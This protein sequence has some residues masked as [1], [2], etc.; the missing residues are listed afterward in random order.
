MTNR[1]QPLEFADI[2]KLGADTTAKLYA[3]STEIFFLIVTFC[4]TTN[5]KK[6]ITIRFL[7]LS[8]HRI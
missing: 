2:A 3:V 4:H 1:K 8:C 7:S 5:F 6:D